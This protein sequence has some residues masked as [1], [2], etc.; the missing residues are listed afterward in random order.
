M[1]FRDLILLRE[2]IDIAD[3]LIHEK[4]F[5]EATGMLHLS[6]PEG[7]GDVFEDMVNAHNDMLTVFCPLL[8]DRR[9][10]DLSDSLGAETRQA[11]KTF[12]SEWYEREGGEQ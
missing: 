9:F 4:C 5:N 8:A 2:L 1:D 6:E 7:I 3:D 11:L 10:S 12:V